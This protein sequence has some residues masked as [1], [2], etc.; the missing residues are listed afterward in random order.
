MAPRS[1][2]EITTSSV[3]RLVKEEASYHRELQEQTKRIKKLESHGGEDENREYMLKQ[4]RL[5]LEETKNVLPSLKQKIEEAIVK[6]QS[7]LTEEGNKGPESNI[8]QI[9]AGKD[10]ISKARTAEREIA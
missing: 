8:E 6:L 4:E 10:A 5:A 3:L 7:L 2:L 1:Q 9:N